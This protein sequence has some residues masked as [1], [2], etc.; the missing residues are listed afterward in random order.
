[1]IVAVLDT[2]V[3]AAG[4]AGSPRLDST[5]GEIVRRWRRGA[6]GLV[7]SEPILAELAHAF[8]QPYFTQRLSSA[9]IGEAFSG[10]RAEARM[11]PV[12]VHVAGIAAHAQDDVILATAASAEAPYL[13]TGDKALLERGAF[14]GTTLLTPRQFLQ[15]LDQEKLVE[16]A[17]S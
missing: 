1:V 15:V 7:V 3:L 14:R 16:H 9:E 8:R 11:Q 2:N 6:F 10:L 4:F 5:P 13:V 17:R 12:T